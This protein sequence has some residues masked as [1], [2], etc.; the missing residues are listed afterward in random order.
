MGSTDF[1]YS[2]SRCHVLG[3]QIMKCLTFL[4]GNLNKY[5]LCSKSYLCFKNIIWF[6]FLILLSLVIHIYSFQL[7]SCFKILPIFIRL[8]FFLSD[9]PVSRFSNLSLENCPESFS[10]TE[11]QGELGLLI[12]IDLVFK[13]LP[14]CGFPL[15]PLG[16][17]SCL[18]SGLHD[19]QLA[20]IEQLGA[21]LTKNP[22]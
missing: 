19:P 5:S 11:L 4:K 1:I 9:F 18:H 15:S 17:M 12:P 20:C 16:W 3:Y 8:I 10:E 21:L 7:C 14:F 2:Q 13:I 22:D 6:L